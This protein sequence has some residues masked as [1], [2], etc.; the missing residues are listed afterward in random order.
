MS[1]G[2]GV[3][4]DS[5]S[6]SGVLVAVSVGVAVGAATGSLGMRSAF[7]GTAFGLNSRETRYG[8]SLI[9]WGLPWP[10]LPEM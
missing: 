9:F 6:G 4:S 5:A 2:I 10:K 8:V 1:V 7:S 3:I